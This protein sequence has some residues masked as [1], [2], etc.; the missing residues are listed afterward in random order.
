MLSAIRQLM[1]PPV[2][3]RSGIGFTANSDEKP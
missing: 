1:N 2:P 3:K